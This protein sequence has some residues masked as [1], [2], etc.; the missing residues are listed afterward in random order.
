MG[1]ITGK[2]IIDRERCKGCE[3][4]ITV[5]PKGILAIDET[6]NSYGFTP[7]ILRNSGQCNACAQCAEICPDIAIEV[8]KDSKG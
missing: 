8:F 4:C 7:V 1:K 3:L 6:I 2:I 5:C